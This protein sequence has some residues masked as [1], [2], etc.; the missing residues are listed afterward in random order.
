MPGMAIGALSVVVAAI[1]AIISR[2]RKS[3]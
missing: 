1:V 2:L 3:T